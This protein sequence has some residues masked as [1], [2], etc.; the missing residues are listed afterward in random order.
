MARRRPVIDGAGEDRLADLLRTRGRHRPGIFEEPQAGGIERQAQIGKQ[1]A[2][3]GFGVV[4]QRFVEEAMDTAGQHVVE[5]RHELDVIGIVSPYIAQIIGE[6]PAALEV[7]GERR[8]PTG[9]RNGAADFDYPGV[10]GG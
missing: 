4:H 10:G 1:P 9:Q 3:L 8:E 2:D 6:I 7:L 5:V